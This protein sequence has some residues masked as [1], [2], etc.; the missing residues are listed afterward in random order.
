MKKPN[1]IFTPALFLLAIVWPLFS[2]PAKLSDYPDY[3]KFIEQAKSHLKTCSYKDAID[4]LKQ[5]KKMGKDTD[6][7]I[8]YYYRISDRAEKRKQEILFL[9]E[10]CNIDQKYLLKAEYANLNCTPN[11]GRYWLT[12]IHTDKLSD[13]VGYYRV[14]GQNQMLSKQYL[15]AYSSYEQSFVL[16]PKQPQV[17]YQLLRLSQL[18][19]DPRS[20]FRWARIFLGNGQ[21][22]EKF[23]ENRVRFQALLDSAR[24]GEEKYY[25]YSLKKINNLN[26]FIRQKEQILTEIERLSTSRPDHAYRFA[27]HFYKYFP[28]ERQFHALLLANCWKQK[29]T[30]PYRQYLSHRAIIFYRSIPYTIQW[31]DSYLLAGYYLKSLSLYRRAFAMSLQSRGLKFN[32][33]VLFFLRRNYYKLHQ[34]PDYQAIDFLIEKTR[35]SQQLTYRQLQSE[36]IRSNQNRELLIYTIHFLKQNKD[37]KNLAKLQKTLTQRDQ[38]N[39]QKE[40]LL[41]TP[42]P[43]LP[44][45][46]GP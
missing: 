24:L 2:F 22:K 29:N 18:L 4:N 25:R 40:L 3:S 26:P 10:K 23:L 19:N 14:L 1:F 20:G 12:R 27:D 36:I 44:K 11:R 35:N 45:A 6:G 28:T 41:A 17:S 34:Q 37:Q 33:E 30:C 42:A 39:E 8:A 43:P 15:A 46:T 16:N 13:D 7:Q 31:A 21:K 5:A 38:R 32:R 9:L